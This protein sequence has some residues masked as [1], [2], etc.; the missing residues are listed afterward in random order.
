MALSRGRLP[1]YV[2]HQAFRLL[3]L[4]LGNKAKV[5]RS[6]TRLCMV[7]HRLLFLHAMYNR[8]RSTSLLISII[9]RAFYVHFYSFDMYVCPTALFN[10]PPLLDPVG[11]LPSSEFYEMCGFWPGQFQ[12]ISDNLLLIPGRIVCPRAQCTAP[13]QLAIFVM[14]RHWKKADKWEDVARV[15]RRGHIWCINVYRQFFP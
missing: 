15:M 4:L 12:E 9:F 6:H 1:S 14:L 7:S 10:Q 2:C 8:H 11:E 3:S 13:K 5:S